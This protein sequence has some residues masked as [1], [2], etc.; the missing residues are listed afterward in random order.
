MG[1]AWAGRLAD[2]REK[3]EYFFSIAE[4]WAEPSF[5]VL[6]AHAF[7][8]RIVLNLVALEVAECEIMAVWMREVDATHG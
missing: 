8:V 7:P 4:P 6:D 3:E 1:C 2:A 5:G